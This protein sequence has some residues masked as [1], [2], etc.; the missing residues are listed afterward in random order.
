MSL[1]DNLNDLLPEILPSDPRDAI[2]GTE[3]IRLVQLKLDDAYSD[4][5]LRYHFSIMSCDPSSPIAKVERGQGYYLRTSQ[6]PALSSAQ[7]LLSFKQIQLTG[8]GDDLEAS[9]HQIN[10]LHKFHAIVQ[11]YTERQG[12]FPFVFRE[13]LKTGAPLGN[14][15]RFPELVQVEWDVDGEAGEDLALDK[16]SISIRQSQGIP[17]Y[18]LKSIRLRT[19]CSME[20]FREDFFQAVS[21]SMWAQSGHLYY[22]CAIEDEG[23][24]EVI[25]LLS[26]R[27]GVGVTTFGLSLEGIDDLPNTEYL[28]N[29][30]PRETEALME[31]I[32]ITVVSNSVQKDQLDWKSLSQVRNESPEI[33]QL[34]AW[35]NRCLE[36]GRVLPILD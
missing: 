31:R 28:L 25:R 15:W 21:S 35:I 20:T 36:Q 1:R 9:S 3:L 5:S 7:E 6:I 10:R 33:S 8:L 19:F 24:L 26:S 17:P 22:A 27:F 23:L 30:N 13:A 16:E 2:K 32:Q 12:L 18:A 34:F 29:A 11:K 14:L 4:A